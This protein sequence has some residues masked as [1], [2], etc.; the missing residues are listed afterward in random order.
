M[1]YD[2]KT[3]FILKPYF[4]ESNIG[5]LQ[6]DQVII[7]SKV[8]A[9]LGNIVAILGKPFTVVGTLYPTGSGMDQTI[10]LNIDVARKLANDV[11]ELQYLW[12]DAKPDDL[13]SSIL[14]HTKDD[15]SKSEVANEINRSN[16]GV[17][18]VATSETI[19]NIRSQMDIISKVIFGLCLAT[20]IIAILSLVGRFNSLAKERK[21]EIGL[22]RAI[23]IQKRQ[24]FQ[25]ILLEAWFMA[26]AG[27]VVGSILGCI[28]ATPFMGI[29]GR[30]FTLPSGIWTWGTALQS[31]AFGILVALLMGAS[32]SVCPAWSSASL[33]PQEAITQGALE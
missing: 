10:F 2:D 7:G 27:G 32:A 14:I 6:D 20:L 23:G 21:R 15:L 29:L 31:S 9:H 11:P 4:K 13:V 26:I 25:L 1:G 17:Q 19:N 28:S 18:A 33:D 5:T 24:I 3:D 12:K 8:E 30:A 16:P 22:L